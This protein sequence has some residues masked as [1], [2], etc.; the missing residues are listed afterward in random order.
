MA[1]I[2]QQLG[3]EERLASAQTGHAPLAVLDGG[4]GDP[5][6]PALL[7][8]AATDE[9]AQFLLDVSQYG[10][11]NVTV[12]VRFSMASA[13]TGNVVLTAALMAYTPGDAVDLVTDTF[14]AVNSATISVPG[15]AGHMKEGT[16]T[17]S[18]LDSLA[19]GDYALLKITRDADHASDTA[20]GDMEFTGVQIEYSNV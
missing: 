12:K 16:I 19:G 1:T 20:S 5:Q 14:A 15:T 6:I 4:A 2:K 8:D 17:I 13:T 10:S 7:F 3:P 9:E 11:G 18:N